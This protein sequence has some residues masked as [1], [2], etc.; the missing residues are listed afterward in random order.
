MI[1]AA[2][3]SRTAAKR[4]SVYDG[5]NRANAAING[6]TAPSGQL[7]TASASFT[8]VSNVLNETGVNGN[9]ATVPFPYNDFLV[10]LKCPSISITGVNIIGRI[11][12]AGYYIASIDGSGQ[13]RLLK[14]ISPSTFTALTVQNGFVAGDTVGLFCKGSTI[15]LLKNG[16]VV[17]STTDTALPTGTSI[18]L[19]SGTTSSPKLMDDFKVYLL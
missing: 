18:G 4:L 9:T 14:F 13:Y 5:F 2:T 17:F 19:R 12:A 15:A 8:I 11:S 10:T 16:V 3:R 6:V 7:W 1:G